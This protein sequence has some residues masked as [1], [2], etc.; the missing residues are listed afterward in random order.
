MPFSLWHIR[1][2]MISTWPITSDVNLGHL[3]KIV[4][5]EFFLYKVTIFPLLFGNKSLNPAQ[6]QEDGN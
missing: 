4:S 6:T 5:A 2:F 1:G 3:N